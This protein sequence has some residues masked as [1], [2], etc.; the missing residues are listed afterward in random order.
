MRASGILMPISSLPSPYGIGTMGQQARQ[1]V[2]FL[3]QAGQAYWQILP[4]CPTSY[5]D[6]PYQSFSTYAG[7]PYFIDL[8]TLAAQGLLKP[9]E[10]KHIDWQCTPEQINYGALYEKR[11]AV[12][13]TACE[14]LLAAPPADYRDFVRKNRFWLPDYALFMALKDAHGGACWQE[15]EHPLRKR[16]PDALKAARRTYAK[17]IAFWQAVQYLFCTQWQ[18]LKEYANDKHIQIIGD[19]P[20]YIALD[21]VDVWSSP[22]DFQLDADLNPTEVAGCPPDGFSATGQLWGNPL[23]DWDAMAQNGYA[24]WVR[25]IRHMCSIYD[26]VRIDHFRAFSA[27]WAV[28]AEAETAKEGQWLDGPKTDFFD[29][30]NRTFKNPKIIA[31]DLGIIDDGVIELLEKTQLPCMRV[32]QF[33]FMEGKDNMHMPHNYPKNCVAYTGTHDNNT[34]L[35]WLWEAQPYE[36]EHALKYCAFPGGDWAVGGSE[37]ASCH[38]IIRTLWQSPANTVIVP[39][40]DLCGFGKDTKMNVPG[41][42]NGNWA[43][44]VTQ[45]QLDGI[46]KKW[47]KELNDVYYRS[48]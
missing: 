7:N 39:V 44:R 27:Y 14:R 28:P 4:V 42:P 43:F 21:S 31:E 13:R 17:D 10:Y 23:Y 34:V 20:I 29:A 12:L 5:G 36:R 2:D 24:W 16:E 22:Q 25:R 30:V 40:Q 46:D 33:A 9:K 8:D 19:L 41:V 45:E 15:W 26:V 47:L 11:Y 38:A 18:A 35:G 32:M 3:S 1:F 6:S 37:S 48:K